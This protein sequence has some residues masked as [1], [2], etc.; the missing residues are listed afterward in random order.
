ML[1]GYMYDDNFHHNNGTQLY[2]GVTDTALWKRQW[3]H[4]STLLASWYARL[5]GVAGLWLIS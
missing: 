5:P 1:L 3:K 2:R 4:L